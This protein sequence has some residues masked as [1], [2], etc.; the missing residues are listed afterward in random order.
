MGLYAPGHMNDPLYSQLSYNS[1]LSNTSKLKLGYD[2]KLFLV[3]MKATTGKD[4]ADYVIR[5]AEV[6]PTSLYKICFA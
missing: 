6:I 3:E 2:V 4:I 1:S 5:A